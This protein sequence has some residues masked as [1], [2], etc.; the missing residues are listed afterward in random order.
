MA[1]GAKSLNVT[2]TAVDSENEAANSKVT[3][4]NVTLTTTTGHVDVGRGTLELTGTTSLTVGGLLRT[5]VNGD[6][7]RFVMNPG[8][9]VS[10]PNG[11]DFAANGVD[12]SSLHL[13]G[14]TLTTPFLYGND[15]AGVTHVIFNGTTVVASASNA[16]FLQVHL[17]G[18]PDPHSAAARIGIG[19]VI[20]DT[21]G[22]D[23]TIGAPLHDHTA[24]GT[25]TKEGP[26]RGAPMVMSWPL[27]L[28][29]APP[30]PM[31]PAALCRCGFSSR[32]T[33]R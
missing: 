9:S 25:L 32:W 30:T 21:N 28:K 4:H 6:W 18:N 22:H 3:L 10:A 8:T 12:A 23:I 13:N 19:G 24:N 1:L 31:R 20:F 33:W 7:S 27:L 14:G 15:Y 26:G 29:I 17:D 5:G 16:D 2:G 11:V